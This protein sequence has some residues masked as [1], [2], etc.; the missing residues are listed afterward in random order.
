MN[1]KIC[2]AE[3]N[4]FLM[5][6]IKEK[7]SFFEDI[8][9]KF[10][11]NNGAELIG[12][13]EENHNIDVILMDIQMPVMDG[14]TAARALR[15]RYSADALPIIAMTAHAMSGDREKS[16]AAGMNAHIT[17]PIVLSELFE[18]LTHWIKHKHNHH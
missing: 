12:K 1:L 13:L 6:A 7:L 5:K 10:T 15:E 14:L 18:T 17:K 4:Y 16:L 9:I 3:D 2:I 8:S 11:G